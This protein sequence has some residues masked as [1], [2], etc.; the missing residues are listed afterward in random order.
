MKYLGLSPFLLCCW[1]LHLFLF[2]LSDEESE[3]IHE[4]MSENSQGCRGSFFVLKGHKG[5]TR[6]GKTEVFVA[7]RFVERLYLKPESLTSWLAFIPQQILPLSSVSF[8]STCAFHKERW[9]EINCLGLKCILHLL[10]VI[11]CQ[12]NFTFHLWGMGYVL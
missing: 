1:S 7:Q 6:G 9:T 12:Q 11:F 8:T 4:G 2:P 3:A 5:V 10:V